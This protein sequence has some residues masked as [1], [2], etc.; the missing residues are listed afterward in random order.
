MFKTLLSFIEASRESFDNL[1]SAIGV[2]DLDGCLIYGNPSFETLWK[3]S[4]SECLG[5]PVENIFLTGMQGIH[6]VLKSGRQTACSS[7]LPNGMCGVSYRTPIISGGHLLGVLAETIATTSSQTKFFALQRLLSELDRS[8]EH[9]G[10]EAF[11]K[12]IT[13]VS[14]DDLV[15]ES[16]TMLRL[17]GLARRF[18]KVN[19]PVLISGE[20][21]VGKDI[22]AQAMH[23]A[24]PRKDGPFV[25]VNC[26]AIPATLMEAELFGYAAGSF[27]GASRF[28]MK[29]KF[30]IAAG[31]T[32][33]LDEI[34]ELP[35]EM[36][37]KL[38]RALEKNEVQKI[39]QA[40]PMRVDFRLVAATNRDL[41]SMV[42]KGLFREDLYQR[43]NM[44][45]LHIPP[46]REHRED[47]PL[48]CHVLVAALEGVKRARA[49]RVSDEVMELFFA[50]NWSGNVRELRNV[51]RFALFSMG[52]DENVVRREHLPER[53]LR[54]REHEKA[55]LTAG[56]QKTERGLIEEALKQ[57][58]G[59][60]TKAAA[61][62]G[63]SRN[64]LY[65]KMKKF[66]LQVCS[67][68]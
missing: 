53:F 59:N 66:E 32:I 63:I 19:D 44:F 33:F 42:E 38:L 20:N 43:I 26:A 34:G 6:E 14:F 30:E 31:G 2:F 9:D 15:G 55:G 3:L 25:T 52:A 29:G 49:V 51:L 41:E 17:K 1:H 39:G 7:I 60:R 10:G 58:Q 12:E 4:L 54:K 46:L 45:E 47:L 62:L 23:N 8:G 5:R 64:C 50:S 37:P 27:T 67:N 61:K 40:A 57:C 56:R 13:P 35:F 24:S 28:G 65:Q 68:A 16:P 22:V 36:Q 48:L 21:G 18:A 11:L